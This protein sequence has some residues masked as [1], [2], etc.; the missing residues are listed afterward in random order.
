MGYLRLVLFLG[1]TITCLVNL[2]ESF[3]SGAPSGAC[4]TL[5]PNPTRHGADPQTTPVPYE[6]DLSA[7]RN[8]NTDTY[9]YIPEE[10]Y[11][12]M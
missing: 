9:C 5:S 3:S 10:T 6:V 7:L 1:I 2:V 12:R 4:G 8:G 11:E